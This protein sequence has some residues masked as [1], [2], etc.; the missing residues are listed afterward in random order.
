VSRE[1]DTDT[2]YRCPYLGELQNGP[3]TCEIQQ[4]MAEY[5]IDSENGKLVLKS[6]FTPLNDSDIYNGVFLSTQNSCYPY[7]DGTVNSRPYVS[8]AKMMLAVSEISTDFEAE[9]NRI[10]GLFLTN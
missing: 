1:V 10:L 2:G 6:L 4:Q 9:K 5:M 3:L 7:M 8:L